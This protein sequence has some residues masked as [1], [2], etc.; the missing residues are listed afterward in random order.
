MRNPIHNSNVVFRCPSNLKDRM[1]AFA[2]GN[3]ERLSAFIR[4]ACM[5]VLKREASSAPQLKENAR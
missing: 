5:E 4:S 3:G 2:E 1:R